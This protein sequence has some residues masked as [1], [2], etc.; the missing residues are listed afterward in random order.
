MQHTFLLKSIIALG[1]GTLS[2][3]A[4]ANSLPFMANDQQIESSFGASYDF[5]YDNNNRK[6]EGINYFFNLDFEHKYKINK[7]YN[8]VFGLF[9]EYDSLHQDN[10]DD[11][12]FLEFNLNNN[13][14]FSLGKYQ[15]NVKSIIDTTDIFNYSNYDK[16]NFK[17]KNTGVITY[18]YKYGNINTAFAYG[19]PKQLNEQEYSAYDNKVNSNNQVQKTFSTSLGYKLDLGPLFD[20]HYGF[21]Y[22]YNPNLSATTFNSNVHNYVHHALALTYGTKQS[23]LYIAFMYNNRK[24]NMYKQLTS[25]SDYYVSGTEL[26]VKRSLSNFLNLALGYEHITMD[27][28]KNSSVNV[29]NIPLELTFNILQNFNVWTQ[30]RFNISHKNNT[31]DSIFNDWNEKFSNFDENSYSAGFIYNF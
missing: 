18:K 3:S 14:S 23:D 12:L 4:K 30:A 15:D 26:V 19:T 8:I 6:K 25:S 20:M 29:I 31:T 5:N 24:Y 7:N 17:H 10:I 1:I 2:I 11:M 21:S 28:V 27:T 22:A 9:F 16:Y 13:N